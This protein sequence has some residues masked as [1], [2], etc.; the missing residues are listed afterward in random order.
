MFFYACVVV[1]PHSTPPLVVCTMPRFAIRE[2]ACA[3]FRTGV[4][5]AANR[6]WKTVRCPV[7]KTRST[8]AL[9]VTEDD[10]ECPDVDAEDASKC[11]T[12]EPRPS[13][14]S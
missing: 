1:V 12:Y 14:H 10:L 11:R 13:R 3:L 7:V 5:S 2:L 4:C 9:D 6:Y 8:E